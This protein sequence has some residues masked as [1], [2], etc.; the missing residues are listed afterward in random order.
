MFRLN[1]ALFRLFIRL[2]TERHINR[3]R[4]C[5]TTQR[6]CRQCS[7]RPTQYVTLTAGR[8]ENLAQHTAVIAYQAY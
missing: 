7:V 2:Q 1:S 3:V 5:I 8:E 6:V 4:Y